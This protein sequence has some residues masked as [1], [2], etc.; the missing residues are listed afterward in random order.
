MKL[1]DGVKEGIAVETD[2]MSKVD[3]PLSPDLL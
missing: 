3:K 2:K 1:K